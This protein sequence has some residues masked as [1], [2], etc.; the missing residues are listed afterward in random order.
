M[1]RYLMTLWAALGVPAV[2]LA[3]AMPRYAPVHRG[4]AGWL[5]I[6]AALVALA[7]VLWGYSSGPKRP[8]RRL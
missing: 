3:Q 7:L 2:A 4:G 8:G 5:W 6:V 1:T